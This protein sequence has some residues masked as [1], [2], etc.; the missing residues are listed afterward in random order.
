MEE[1]ETWLRRARLDKKWR[2]SMKEI[3]S[4]IRSYI[5]ITMNFECLVGSIINKSSINENIN[6]SGLITTY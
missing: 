6:P 2:V 5:Y 1:R 3:S 4:K